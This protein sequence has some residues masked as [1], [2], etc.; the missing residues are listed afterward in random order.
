M[1]IAEIKY[2]DSTAASI[3]LNLP[4][5]QP[6]A[7]AALCLYCLDIFLSYPIQFYVIMDII[8]QSTT[9]EIRDHSI[10]YYWWW[11]DHH[12]RKTLLLIFD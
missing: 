9:P 10:S 11:L 12:H 1:G 5:G 2:G 8:G 7:E 4:R 3:T 6:L